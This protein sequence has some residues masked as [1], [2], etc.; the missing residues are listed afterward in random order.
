M[1]EILI[2]IAGTIVTLMVVVGTF[3]FT[4]FEFSRMGR[5]PERFTNSR[6]RQGNFNRTKS[7]NPKGNDSGISEPEAS[8]TT[9]D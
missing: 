2:F 9:L 1:P 6:M 7:Q 5:N 3:L 4:F 8:I